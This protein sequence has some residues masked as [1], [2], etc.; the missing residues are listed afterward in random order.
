MSINK[1]IHLFLYIK[2]NSCF[3]LLRHIEY[4]LQTGKKSFLIDKIILTLKL[5]FVKKTFY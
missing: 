2:Q 5:Q 3:V 4:L 1:F